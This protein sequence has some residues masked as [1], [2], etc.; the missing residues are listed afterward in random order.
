MEK[1][2]IMELVKLF[3][4]PNAKYAFDAPTSKLLQIEEA[5]YQFLKNGGENVSDNQKEQRY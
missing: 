1:G 5:T 2:D 3:S 4:T